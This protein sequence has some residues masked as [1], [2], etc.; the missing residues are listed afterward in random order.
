M[1]NYPK[2]VTLQRVEYL[3]KRGSR[4]IRLPKTAKSFSI[5]ETA[6]KRYNMVM[7]VLFTEIQIF[8]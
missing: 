5:A 1:G 7:V 4:A 2:A 8:L 6:V 3:I